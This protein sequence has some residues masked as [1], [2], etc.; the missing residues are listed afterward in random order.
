MRTLFWLP[1]MVISFFE[2]TLDTNKNAFTRAWFEAND[3]ED[4][5]NPEYQDPE[6]DGE[7]QG[8]I[9]KVKF[10]DLVKDFP[11]TSVVR[12]TPSRVCHPL[13]I[14]PQGMEATII[15]EI[16]K[17]KDRIDELAARLEKTQ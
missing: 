7:E 4:D 2:A 3:E 15:A 11:D 8:K 6:V 5:D 14:E 13:T 16:Q 17:L 12:I 9:T 10:A 1:L